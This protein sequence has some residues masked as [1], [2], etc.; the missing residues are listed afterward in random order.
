MMRVV[1][2]ALDLHAVLRR[3]P[4]DEGKLGQVPRQADAAAD[5]DVGLGAVAA[6]PFATGLR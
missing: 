4:A 3:G 1:E 6:K 5:D 2:D